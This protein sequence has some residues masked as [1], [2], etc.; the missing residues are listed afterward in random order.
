MVIDPLPE[1]RGPT[2]ETGTGADQLSPLS[3]DLLARTTLLS[4]NVTITFPLASAAIVDWSPAEIGTGS[5]HVAPLL[6][7]VLA[8]TVAT[9]PSSL[10][11]TAT[12]LPK[13]SNVSPK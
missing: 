6:V 3:V 12:A 5:D 4:S 10:R 7:D 2:S 13:E 8:S 1:V 9:D 11:Q